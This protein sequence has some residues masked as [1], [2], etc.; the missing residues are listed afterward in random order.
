MDIVG[1]IVFGFL[2]ISLDMLYFNEFLIYTT[3]SNGSIG[4]MVGNIISR[5]FQWYMTFPLTP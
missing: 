4:Y 3:S 2:M 1:K 5:P